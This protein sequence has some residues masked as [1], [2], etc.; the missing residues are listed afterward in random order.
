MEVI[1]AAN[2]YLNL[3]WSF[4]PCNGKVPVKGVLVKDYMRR[5]PYTTE[6]DGWW[7]LWP[8]A[9]IGILT[10][11]VSGITGI[12]IDPNADLDEFESLLPDGLEPPVC[13]TPR[14]GRHMYFKYVPGVKNGYI[15]KDV[16]VK[17]DGGKLTAPPTPGYEW[18][19][20]PGDN[21]PEMPEQLRA[22]VMKSRPIATAPAGAKT[23]VALSEGSRN[24]TLFTTALHLFKGGMPAKEVAEVVYAMAAAS[25]PPLDRGETRSIIKSAQ[26]R[27]FTKEKN[28]S[29][30]VRKW[31]DNMDGYFSIVDLFRSMGIPEKDKQAVRQALHRMLKERVIMKWGE[32]SGV[33]RRL[34]TDCEEMDYLD[35]PTE[36]MDVKLPMGLE[37]YVLLFPGNIVVVA[38]ASNAGKTTW[39]MNFAAMNQDKYPVHYFNS[40]MGGTELKIR[41][42]HFEKPMPWKTKFY[43]RS[44]KFSDVIV[45]GAINIIDYL[46]I[47]GEFYAIANTIREIHDKLGGGLCL[48]GL[49]KD[50]KSELGRGG[51][52]GLEKP[53]LYLAMDHGRMRVVKAKNWKGLDNPN[54]FV[55]DFN[56]VHGAKFVPQSSWRRETYD[57]GKAREE[58][59]KRLF[60]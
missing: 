15:M 27:A 13:K 10:G 40:E 30:E 14:G 33:Y 56:L 58:K 31:V 44:E 59:T 43:E 22:L 28:I 11:Q 21:V 36:G 42:S 60:R 2:E 5:L 9:G 1:K 26:D 37:E 57:E 53:R 38:G 16:E 25:Q 17:G 41:L 24:N 55:I 19:I 4:V 49:Q 29:V 6:I 46:E 34:M 20:P 45:P 23:P 54:G 48:I 7:K 18:I 32:K 52:F 35:A 47:A 51:A 3:K 8:D 50:V 12:D 39:L